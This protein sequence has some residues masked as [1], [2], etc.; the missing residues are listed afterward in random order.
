[1]LYGG[2]KLKT[3]DFKEE[4]NEISLCEFSKMSRWGD[5]T[6]TPTSQYEQSYSG[7][8]DYELKER[9]TPCP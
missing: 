3:N 9:V 4:A 2:R 7:I 1:M 6:S 5:M 8:E